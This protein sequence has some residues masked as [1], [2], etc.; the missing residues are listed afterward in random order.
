MIYTVHAPC[1]LIVIPNPH[2]CT[3]TTPVP[4]SVSLFMAESHNTAARH[5]LLFLPLCHWVLCSYSLYCTAQALAHF[6]SLYTRPW[7]FPPAP[8]EVTGEHQTWF[9]KSVPLSWG[10]HLF[11]LLNLK[12]FKQRTFYRTFRIENSV[13]DVKEK[14]FSSIYNRRLGR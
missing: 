5:S 2:A 13:I 10:Q 6:C 4:H 1:A 12:V 3:H 9:S 11:S 14:S 8:F 7:H